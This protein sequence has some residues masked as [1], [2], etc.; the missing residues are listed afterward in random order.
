M[1]TL[2]TWLIACSVLGFFLARYWLAQKR[3]ETAARAALERGPLFVEGPRAQHPKIDL[4]ARIG[5]G[6]A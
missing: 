3:K 6:A 2:L 5:C 1:D 4:N